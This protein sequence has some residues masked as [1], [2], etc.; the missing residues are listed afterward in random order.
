MPRPLRSLRG[1][2]LPELLV[3]V[4]IIGLGVI[5][6]L[7]RDKQ[8]R[9]PGRGL[10]WPQRERIAHAQRS[11]RKGAQNH[12]CALGIGGHILCALSS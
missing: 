8:R 10:R 6:A 4:S 9:D 2:T 12:G 7:S 3:V 5:G 11:P 1:V